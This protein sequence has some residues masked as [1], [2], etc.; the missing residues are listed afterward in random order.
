V[1]INDFLGREMAKVKGEKEVSK[2]LLQF[3][4][5]SRGRLGLGL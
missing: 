4:R 3:E 5:A 1:R 2:G